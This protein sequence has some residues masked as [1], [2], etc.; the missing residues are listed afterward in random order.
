MHIF[1]KYKYFLS[2]GA[3]NDEKYNSARQGLTQKDNDAFNKQ[4][5]NNFK[6]KRQIETIWAQ[7]YLA[8]LN[9]WLITLTS[10][11]MDHAT[12]DFNTYR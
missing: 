3:S 2:S 5:L 12:I 6:L 9:Y 4:K 11:Y 7:K 10:D 1:K 8:R